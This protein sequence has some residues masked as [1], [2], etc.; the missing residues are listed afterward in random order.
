MSLLR[1]FNN[2]GFDI[3]FI[4]K[5]ESS[6]LEMQTEQMKNIEKMSLQDIIDKFNLKLLSLKN[7]WNLEGNHKSYDISDGLDTLLEEL[8]TEPDYGYP[9]LN[10]Y[11]NTIFR[12]MRMGKYMIRSASTGVGR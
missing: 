8:H 1:D 4:Y 12:G 9:F 3:S 2:Q 5:P 7:D 6:D 11:Y 10:G